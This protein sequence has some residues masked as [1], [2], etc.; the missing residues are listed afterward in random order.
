MSDEWRFQKHVKAI[1]LPTGYNPQDSIWL[2]LSNLFEGRTTDM[3]QTGVIASEL[4]DLSRLEQSNALSKSSGTCGTCSQF[5]LGNCWWRIW[6]LIAKAHEGPGDVLC[7]LCGEEE[8]E[9][10]HR[11]HVQCVPHDGHTIEKWLA[12]NSGLS[13]VQY[14]WWLILISNQRFPYSTSEFRWW[15]V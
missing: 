7:F 13:N 14:I 10:V 6:L 2:N 15:F 5:K 11:K 8:I 9:K 1:W 3:R 4:T 12:H